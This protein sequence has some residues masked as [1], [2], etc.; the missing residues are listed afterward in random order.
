MD[1][2]QHADGL[3]L[4]EIRYVKSADQTYPNTLLHSGPEFLR[5][6]EWPATP[7]R[8]RNLSRLHCDHWLK[9]LMLLVRKVRPLSRRTLFGIRIRLDLKLRH[10]CS[11]G[12]YRFQLDLRQWIGNARTYLDIVGIN[13][14][15]EKQT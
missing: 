9:Y 2:P 3:C 10:V 11:N 1:I 5:D 12:L 13:M 8:R 4:R 15:I 7:P 6:K 14:G